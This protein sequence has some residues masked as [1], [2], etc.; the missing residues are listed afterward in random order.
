[1]GKGFVGSGA[2]ASMKSNADQ[3]QSGATRRMLNP[4]VILDTLDGLKMRYLKP[5]K[6]HRK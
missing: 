2:A 1:M 5:D 4:Q 3:S 6:N